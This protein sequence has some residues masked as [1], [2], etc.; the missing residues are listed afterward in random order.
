MQA[1]YRFRFDVAHLIRSTQRYR[2]TRAIIRAWTI[3]G[4]LAAVPAAA[5][6]WFCWLIGE[7]WVASLC[8]AAVITLLFNWPLQKLAIR[9]TFRKSP[10][11]NEDV[12]VEFGADGVRVKGTIQDT[13]LTWAVY[14]SARRFKDGMLL[15]QGPHMYS[16]MPDSAATDSTSVAGLGELARTQVRDYREV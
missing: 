14:T 5:L 16:W 15:F 6:A 1:N 12:Q 3:F 9:Y 13:R 8:V 4:Y 2:Q 11:S 10:F 7:N